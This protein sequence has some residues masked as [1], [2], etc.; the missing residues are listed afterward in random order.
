MLTVPTV[1]LTEG[2]ADVIGLAPQ[3]KEAAMRG[4]LVEWTGDELTFAAQD[5]LSGGVSSWVPG[6]GEEGRDETGEL[7]HWG[8]DD[9][10]W[11]V[12][13]DHDDA[14]QIMKNFKL[15]SRYRLTPLTVKVNPT[16]SRLIVERS[17]DTGRRASLLM[18]P[19]D[20]E[21]VRLFPDVRRIAQDAVI[22]W[23]DGA[24]GVAYSG[25]RLAAFGAV[26]A[27]GVTQLMFGAGKD[28]PTAVKIGARFTGFIYPD[29]AKVLPPPALGSAGSDLL[30]SGAGLHVVRDTDTKPDLNVY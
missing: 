5:V 1:E 6:E 18:V 8:G 24:P 4:V 19:S 17:Q 27:H 13:V 10:P 2:F 9:A 14:K 21:S 28:R 3:S 29:G 15:A 26:R 16:G 7:I 22:G 20:P 25:A 23:A 12:F 30:R 11:R